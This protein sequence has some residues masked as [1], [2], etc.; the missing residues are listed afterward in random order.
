MCSGPT[1][2]LSNLGF[3]N[4]F[5]NP[6]GGFQD[7]LVSGVRRPKRFL[8]QP[9]CARCRMDDRPEPFSDG[10]IVAHGRQNPPHTG[11][12]VPRHVCETC[13]SCC[14]GPKHRLAETNPTC[15]AA[16]HLNTKACAGETARPKVWL[17]PKPA[18]ATE[19]ARQMR[20]A[21]LFAACSLPRL[22]ER[23]K[24]CVDENGDLDGPRASDGMLG[25]VW[26]STLYSMSTM[27]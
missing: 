17:W 24:D 6:L 21:S 11:V 12:Q 15:L 7:E 19:K 8:A 5:P 3:S 13:R 1:R 10:H 4:N 18:H 23:P 26:G 20:G 16:R 2:P 9:S 25:C 22:I 14:V 27:G